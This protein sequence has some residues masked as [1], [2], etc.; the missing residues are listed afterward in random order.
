MLKF[1]LIVLMQLE[2]PCLQK[3]CDINDFLVI[4]SNSMLP[5]QETTFCDNTI[6]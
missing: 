6:P 2:S 5:F 3:K 1:F 4:F